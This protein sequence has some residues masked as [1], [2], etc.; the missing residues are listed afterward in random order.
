VAATIALASCGS[1]DV[2]NVASR[3][4][5]PTA[6]ERPSPVASEAVPECAHQTLIGTVVA[7]DVTARAAPKPSARAIA[8]FPKVNAQGAQQV[9]DLKE[10][11]RGT[12]GELWYPALLPIRPNGSI[13]FIPARQLALSQ[14]SFRLDVD[15]SRLRLTLWRGCQ[16]AA[17]YPIGL[18]KTRTPTPVGDF[19][20][21]SL[22][23][24]PAANSVYG[25][26]AYGLSAY[27]NAI[28]DWR[29]GGVIGLHGTNDPSSIGKRV[30]HGC[31]RM[32]NKDIERLAKMLPL[33]TP[34][35]IH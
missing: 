12:N 4:T 7:R 17:R 20:L 34:I 13:G 21:I 5:P 29:W 8:S 32:R 3:P 18:G 15:R 33:G 11:V 1:A 19:Y 22:M 10:G 2:G 28:T 31:I 30:S 6:A 16:V 27:S 14:T 35:T 9:F 24:P 25:L 26:Y 23:K